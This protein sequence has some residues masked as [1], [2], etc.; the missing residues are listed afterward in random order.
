MDR[1][2]LSSSPRPPQHHRFFPAGS[3]PRAWRGTYVVTAMVS[4]YLNVFVVIARLKALA[5]I[6]VLMVVANRGFRCFG[7][8]CCVAENASPPGWPGV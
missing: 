5:M 6:V 3:P 7:P 8:V 1:P 4:F 2:R